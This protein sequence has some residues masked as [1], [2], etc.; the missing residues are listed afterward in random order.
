MT[1]GSPEQ[2]SGLYAWSRIRRFRVQDLLGRDSPGAA[3]E[4]WPSQLCIREKL[5]QGIGPVRFIV[6]YLNQ[7]TENRHKD[8][9]ELTLREHV[10]SKPL[11]IAED[12]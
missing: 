4:V 6:Q 3:L 9:G 5:D 11:V 12:R 10:Q 1:H 7:G 2:C 8:G